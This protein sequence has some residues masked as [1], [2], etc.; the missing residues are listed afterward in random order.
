MSVYVDKSRNGFGR[1]VMCHLIADTPAELRAMALKIGL[2]LRWF[3][4]RASTPHFDISQSKKAMA[5]AAG[6]IELD[7]RPFVD[8]MKR[9]RNA[10]PHM[11]GCWQL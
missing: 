6:A 10:W 5:I 9:I 7:R 11:D 8:V 4:A 3:Q 2:N 1:M